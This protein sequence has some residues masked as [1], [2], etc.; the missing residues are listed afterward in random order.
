MT[1]WPLKFPLLVLF[2]VFIYVGCLFLQAN[3]GR[4]DESLISGAMEN[5]S[6]TVKPINTIF[7]EK[8]IINVVASYY[9]HIR[10]VY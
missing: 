4:K 7:F 2:V 6:S 1:A 3:E 9:M 8:P 10:T 5:T